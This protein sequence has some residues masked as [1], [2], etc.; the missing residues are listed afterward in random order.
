M[1][2]R[3]VRKKHRSTYIIN[4]KLFPFFLTTLSEIFL[5]KNPT[6]AKMHSTENEISNLMRSIES[7]AIL[8]VNLPK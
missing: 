4:G 8:L 2:T 3:F 5:R 1:I 6:V 7:D